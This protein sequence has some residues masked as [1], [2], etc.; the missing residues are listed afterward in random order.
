MAK[1]RTK[2]PKLDSIDLAILR[3]LQDSSKITNATL[4]K[5]IGISPPSTLERVKKLEAAGII[6]GYV[7]VLDAE[8]LNKPIQAIVQVSLAEHSTAVLAGAK[9]TI[10]TF[11]EVLA[12]WHTAGDEDFILLVVV[13]NMAEYEQFVGEKLSSVMGIGRIRTGF[14]L[15]T[16]KQT[17]AVPLDGVEP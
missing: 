7:A 11:D 14:V 12:C 9:K 8:Q 17:M 13:T 15:R 3:A 16:V 5:R 2:R 4:A 10:G 6:R 1:P